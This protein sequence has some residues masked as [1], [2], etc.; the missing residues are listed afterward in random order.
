MRYL[1]TLLTCLFLAGC[2]HQEPPQTPVEPPT[3]VPTPTPPPVIANAAGTSWTLDLSPWA[4]GWWQKR[5]ATLPD[6]EV[7]LISTDQSTYLNIGGFASDK[8]LILIVP[9]AQKAFMQGGYT[10][11]EPTTVVSG[12]STGMMTGQQM[13]VVWL[14]YTDWATIFATGHHIVFVMCGG[15][16]DNLIQNQTTCDLVILKLSITEP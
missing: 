8:P 5:T 3:T 13:K 7:A 14:H 16:T 10:V 15:E 2:A 1:S 4:A 12:S 9:A 6:S 11:G